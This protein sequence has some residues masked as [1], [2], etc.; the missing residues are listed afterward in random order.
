M[1][2]SMPT[3]G[4]SMMRTSQSAASHLARL[5]FCWLPPESWPACWSGE[6]SPD[7]Q[8]IGVLV[9][10]ATAR[11]GRRTSPSRA[12]R[13]HTVTADVAGDGL[14][15]EEALLLA[16][17]GDV[18]DPVP[19]QGVAHVPDP[20]RTPVHP[21]LAGGDP[22]EA[23]QR[24]GQLAAARADQP[25]QADDLAGADGEA[26][27]VVAG[28]G[29]DGIEDQRRFDVRRRRSGRRGAPA[30]TPGRPSGRRS[31]RGCGRR[32]ARASATLRPSRSTV[33]VSATAKT[34]SS[35]WLTSTM[36]W[37]RS[38]SRRTMP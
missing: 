33:T 30:G 38:D 36:A 34:S 32:G 9:D 5:T 23:E 22:V 27:V 26:D 25:V 21:H 28:G 17:L 35:L 4:S 2:T 1:R 37:P 19:V 24:L 3:V 11:P 15:E 18:A 12:S 16:V 29:G 10:Q 20:G 8:P 14:V 6:A 13:R 31:L 7:A